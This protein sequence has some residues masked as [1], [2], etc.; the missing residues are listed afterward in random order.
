MIDRNLK[1][2][3]VNF[4]AWEEDIPPIV[5]HVAKVEKDSQDYVER[6]VPEVIEKQ[7]GTGKWEIYKCHHGDGNICIYEYMS[8]RI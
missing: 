3:D 8:T 5:D 6:I 7:S 1:E 2:I 4:N